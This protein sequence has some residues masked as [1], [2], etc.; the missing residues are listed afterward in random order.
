[1]RSSLIKL[2]RRF[3]PIRI[4]LV[5]ALVLLSSG[6]TCSGLF[7]SCQG[8]SQAQVKSISP[9]NIPR[10]ADSVPL[11]VTGSGF[12]RQSQIMWNR[13]TLETTFIDSR[14]LQTTITQDTFNDFGGSAGSR[15]QISV[16]SGG[17]GCP[18]NGN[19]A[20]LDLND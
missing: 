1:M 15:V 19:S 10:D 20:T 9:G 13:S 5:A 8:V 6:W 2:C 7:L 12:T 11:M 14:H 16:A 4:A 18:I 17:S 3:S